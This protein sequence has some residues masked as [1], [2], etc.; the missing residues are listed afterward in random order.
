MA[1]LLESWF[2]LMV[3]FGLGLLLG[4]LIWKDDSRAA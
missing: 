1:L 3:F 2:L 4:Y